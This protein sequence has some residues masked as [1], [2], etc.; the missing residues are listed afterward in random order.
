MTSAPINKNA[1]SSSTVEP[2]FQIDGL[3][4][5]VLPGCGLATIEAGGADNLTVNRSTD[6]VEFDKLIVGQKVNCVVSCETNR[7][8]RAQ[9]EIEAGPPAPDGD[10]A[11][12]NPMTKQE[13][14]T[15]YCRR[16]GVAWADISRYRVPVLSGDGA[17]WTMLNIDDNEN[18]Q[19]VHSPLN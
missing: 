19:T 17:R 1:V 5:R 18:D 11:S 3:V 12:R 15:E 8:L 13:F 4:T 16:W 2:T 14:I 7:V 6:G 9:Q 10:S